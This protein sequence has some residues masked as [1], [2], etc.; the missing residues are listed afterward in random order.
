M[1]A[2][3]ETG[4]G[5]R[6]LEERSS[7]VSGPSVIIDDVHLT[8]RV[9][10]DVKPT[11]RKV[12]ARRFKPREYRA[13]H[14]VRGVSL[15]AHPGEAIAVVGR[16]GSGKSTLLKTLA[17]LLPPTQG[18]IYARSTPVL[19]GVGAALQPE[20]SGRRNVYLGGTALG[21]TR[22]EIE[23]RI[24][25][26][27]DFAELRDFI[28]MP[29]RAYSSGMKARLH[30]AIATNVAPEVLLIDESLAVGDAAFKRRSEERIRELLAAAGVVFVVS[31]STG[32]LQ[33]V[34]TRA[35]WMEAGKILA[36]GP[37]EE[38]LE[39]YEDEVDPDGIEERREQRAR[40]AA[41]AAA[42]GQDPSSIDDTARTSST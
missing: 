33:R 15:K 9:Y 36:D 5:V 17:G 13:V 32:V 30:F 24:D 10:E 3:T 14:A 18:A 22:K 34:C 31:H 7:P 40:D 37:V 29:L 38:I 41:R 39:A 27:I 4:T 6:R 42:A 35:V 16:N 19:L 11:L 21:L 25:E 1:D 28:D 20:L 12:V 2:G 26:I 23:D 8:Y